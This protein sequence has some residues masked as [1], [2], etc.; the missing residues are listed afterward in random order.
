MREEPGFGCF[1]AVL[2]LAG[3]LLCYTED[4]EERKRLENEADSAM[5]E[6]YEHR[7]KMDRDDHDGFRTVEARMLMYKELDAK[8]GPGKYTAVYEMRNGWLY[9]SVYPV[10]EGKD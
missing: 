4:S 2:I 3:V 7:L 1:V 8:Y 10:E 5:R 6:K 9:Y